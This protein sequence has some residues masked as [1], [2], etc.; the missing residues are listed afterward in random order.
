MAQVE[1]SLDKG[2]KIMEKK[3]IRFKT[4]LLIS[5]SLGI[6][7]L[8]VAFFV[9]WNNPSGD[10]PEKIKEAETAIEKE[11][12]DIGKVKEEI[13]DKETG[14]T[15]KLVD[16]G[17]TWE[18]ID[19]ITN[20]LIYT[21]E[22]IAKAKALL[23]YEENPI[24][25]YS[26]WAYLWENRYTI[27]NQDWK[28]QSYSSRIVISLRIALLSCIGSIVVILLILTLMPWL[29]YFLLDRISELSQAIQGK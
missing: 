6:I 28:I 7:A 2:S 22:K 4:R 12:E 3:K 8:I 11:F 20:S 27:G 16:L 25:S 21:N 18:K 9:S 24:P 26:W 19:Q 23:H 5:I 17:P 1:G 15:I 10:T 14:E 13:V 29:W